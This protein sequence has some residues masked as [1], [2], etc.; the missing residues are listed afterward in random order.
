MPTLV[1]ADRGRKVAELLFNAFSTT[2]IHGRT[3]M[4]FSIGILY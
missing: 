3:E 2:G 1:D 4:P